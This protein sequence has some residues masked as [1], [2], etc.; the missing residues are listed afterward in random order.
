MLYLDPNKEKLLTF[1]V[2]VSGDA[3]ENIVSH[4]R[5]FIEG[6]ELG[7]P[8]VFK[9][10]KII[11]LI[12]PLRTFF[13]IPLKSGT[14]I[15]SRLDVLSENQ[16]FYSPWQGQIEIKSSF[17]VE[18]KLI[19]DDQVKK[20]PVDTNSKFTIKSIMEDQ[21]DEIIEKA[22]PLQEKKKEV[23]PLPKPVA[24]AAQKPQPKK[25]EPIKEVKSSID[26]AALKK[27]TKEGVIE[28]MA[29]A[30][31][32]NER[33]QEIIYEQATAKAGSGEPFKVLKE[34]VKILSRKSDLS[35]SNYDAKVMEKMMEGR[36]GLNE[37]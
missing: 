11:A 8:A 30:G 28:Y 22:Q 32:K 37:E 7:F 5:L 23:K 12:K 15:E 1:E 19:G 27:I 24:K 6:V 18:A 17:T 14:V 29:R 25:P 31:S 26:V 2:D 20:T 33:I 9:E 3:C 34:V 16:D 35:P 4:V 36:K 13:K 10:S 21:F